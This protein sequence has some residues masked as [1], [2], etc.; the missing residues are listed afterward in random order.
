MFEG[1]GV[2]LRPVEVIS[3][4]YAL[5]EYGLTSAEMIAVEKRI[6]LKMKAVWKRGEVTSFIGNAHDFD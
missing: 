2:A 3:R 5:Q 4:D 6:H 1:N